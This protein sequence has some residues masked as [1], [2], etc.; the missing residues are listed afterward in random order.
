MGL[1]GDLLL[2]SVLSFF[3]SRSWGP[4][5]STSP[6]GETISYKMSVQ[7]D[8][9]F[10]LR[11]HIGRR[12]RP[13]P[14]RRSGFFILFSLLPRYP[15]CDFGLQSFSRKSLRG[16][17]PIACRYGGTSLLRSSPPPEHADPSF[18]RY[19]FLSEGAAVIRQMA[20]TTLDRPRVIG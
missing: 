18:G 10:P 9:P 20:Q 11:V 13:A 8:I 7:A 4:H 6:D 1:P 5:P 14:R 16:G 19:L 2:C 15:Y 3:L 12:S 17:V